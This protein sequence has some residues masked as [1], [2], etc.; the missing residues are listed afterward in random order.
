MFY[1]YSLSG[2]MLVYSAYF[3]VMFSLDTHGQLILIIRIILMVILKEDYRGV[4]LDF[5]VMLSAAQ[6][7]AE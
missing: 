6:K 1:T 5:S 2:L 7:K 4:M 3:G